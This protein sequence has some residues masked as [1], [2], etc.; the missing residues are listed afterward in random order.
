MSKEHKGKTAIT[1]WAEKDLID[2]IDILAD[3]AGLTRSK[4]TKNMLEVCVSHLEV[5]NTL[6]VLSTAVVF[7]DFK[8]KIAKWCEKESK[9]MAKKQTV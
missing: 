2:R 8:E 6:G 5:M 7:R 3:K 4:I 1:V 9:M